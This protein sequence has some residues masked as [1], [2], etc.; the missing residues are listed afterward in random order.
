MLTNATFTAN[1]TQGVF[2]LFFFQSSEFGAEGIGNRDRDFPFQFLQRFGLQAMDFR[3]QFPKVTKR[4][5]CQSKAFFSEMI[6]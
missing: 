4:S 1:K 5:P 6:S 3:K 2:Q